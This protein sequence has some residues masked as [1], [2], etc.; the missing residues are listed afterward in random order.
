MNIR[1]YKPNHFVNFMENKKY[2]I[3]YFSSKKT[4]EFTKKLLELIEEYL[5]CL[6]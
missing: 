4:H 5:K 6:L 3:A 2:A 1:V